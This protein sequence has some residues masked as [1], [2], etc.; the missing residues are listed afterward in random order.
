[1]TN[2]LNQDRDNFAP[3]L[4][5]SWNPK[6]KLVVRANVGLFFGRTPAIALGTAHSN[7]GINVI[8]VTLN[9]VQLPFVYPARFPSLD[10]IRALGGQLA[11]PDIFIFDKNYQQPYTTQAS[12]NL[13]Y[14]LTKTVAVGAAYLHVKGTNLSR[15][16]DL[17]L[18]VPV[19]TTINST[20]PN[21]GDAIVALPFLRH[22]GATAPARPIAG[23]GRISSFEGS[24]DSSYNALT[25][26]FRKRFAQN[27]SFDANYVW[28]KVLDN[29]PDQ[30]S[31]VVGGGDDAKQAQQTFLLRDDKGV[32]NADVPHRFV[33]NALWRLNY[34]GDLNKAARTVLNDWEL[35][36]IVQLSSGAPFTEF[37][38]V[39][40]NNDGNARSDR[41]PARARNSLRGERIETV[42][43]RLTKTFFVTEK[44]RLQLIGE[45]FNVFN[46]TNVV[47]YQ[48]TLYRT[49]GL[50]T[51]TALLTRRTDFL[52]PRGVPA[53]G[54]RIGQLAVK[55]IF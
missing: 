44:V 6:D 30:T 33:M 7:N 15:T 39:D 32:G 48:S 51:A 55:F 10:A 43:A 22:P 9:N 31:V 50:N 29:V 4:G 13:E 20:G 54:Q 2:T 42:D 24:A 47:S 52:D 11:V 41:T 27:F 23:F 46:H 38:G 17:N 36:G 49:T 12:L 45:L 40:L 34:F 16:R 18:G 5:V 26:T 53:D 14:A 1:S 21:A 3:R 28:S 19:A 37:L 25:L 8:G 35:S